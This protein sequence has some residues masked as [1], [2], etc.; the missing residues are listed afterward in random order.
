[1]KKTILLLSDH[2]LSTSGVGT[3]ARWLVSGLVNTGK[4]SFRCFGGAIK[5]ENYDTV[6]VN[7]DFVIKPTD[8]FGDKNLLRKTLA[9]LKPDALMLFTDPRFFYWV[10]EMEEEITKG[11]L[12]THQGNKMIA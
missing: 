12:I 8:G 3:Q 5:H 4:Y 2:P 1:M 11:S 6:V 7:P 10:W 9:Q